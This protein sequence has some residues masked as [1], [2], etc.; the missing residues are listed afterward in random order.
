MDDFQ[1]VEDVAQPRRGWLARNWLWFIPTGCLAVLLVCG[2][3]CAGVAFWGVGRIKH[4]EPY[5]MA[6]AQVRNDAQVIER[7]GQPIEDAT[8]VPSG[9]VNFQ[10]D[11]GDANFGFKVAGPNGRAN[12]R[13]QARLIDGIW[14]LSTL[15]VTFDDG[16]R[17]SLPVGADAGLDD[18]PMW[19]PDDVP[20]EQPEPGTLDWSPD[21]MPTF[22]PEY[23]IPS[24]PE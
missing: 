7:L 4:L 20:E 1:Q 8:L 21:E 2:G 23:S 12:V 6:F 10:N 13:A 16:Q 11:R 18:A 3:L 9:E 15:E 5:K 24:P 19:S 17:I 22:P 14:G